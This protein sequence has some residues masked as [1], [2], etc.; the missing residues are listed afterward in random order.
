[1]WV[2]TQLWLSYPRRGPLLIVL[3]V[4]TIVTAAVPVGG[5]VVGP[6]DAGDIDHRD[7]LPTTALGEVRRGMDQG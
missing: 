4:F 6:H 1:M 7:A 3:I 5:A 2:Q